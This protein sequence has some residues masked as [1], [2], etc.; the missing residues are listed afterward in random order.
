MLLTGPV[1]ILAHVV[2]GTLMREPSSPPVRTTAPAETKVGNFPL[3]GNVNRLAPCLASIVRHIQHDATTRVG[4][5]AR[6][7]LLELPPPLPSVYALETG[8][9]HGLL[10]NLSGCNGCNQISTRA[11]PTLVVLEVVKA[12]RP[13]REERTFRRVTTQIAMLLTI[14]CLRRRVALR[15]NTRMHS[16]VHLARLELTLGTPHKRRSFQGLRSPA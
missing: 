6:P 15:V 1:P 9:R 16:D 10:R 8:L 2:E 13:R 12:K 4:G 3:P 5:A 14:R 7:H 11:R